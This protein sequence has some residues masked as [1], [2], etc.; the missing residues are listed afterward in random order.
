MEGS[1]AEDV[2]DF[3]KPLL[4]T[5]KSVSLQSCQDTRYDDPTNSLLAA[6]KGADYHKLENEIEKK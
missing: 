3:A 4:D 6:N 2:L 5:G 1:I